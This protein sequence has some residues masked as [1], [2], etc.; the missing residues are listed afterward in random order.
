[1]PSAVDNAIRVAASSWRELIRHVTRAAPSTESTAVK[2][3]DVVKRTDHW[4]GESNGQ[5]VARG[6]TKAE[7]VR[8]TANVARS[9][10]EAVSVRI[11]TLDGQ[12]R[13]E[14]TYPR[15]TDPRAGKG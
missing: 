4:V 10:P 5:V 1:M 3:I 2:R 7:A 9:D 15:S 12:I 6:R 13:D 14:R 11:H 8:N